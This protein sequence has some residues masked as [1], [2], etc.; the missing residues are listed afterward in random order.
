MESWSIFDLHFL[1]IKVLDTLH[2]SMT[3][4]NGCWHF[5]FENC[6]LF[7]SLSIELSVLVLF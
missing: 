5:I 7:V 6:M 1:I 3:L 2:M 4:L